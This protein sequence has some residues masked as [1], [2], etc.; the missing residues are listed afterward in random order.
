MA[1]QFY[2]RSYSGSGNIV[3]TFEKPVRKIVI[4]A[5]TQAYINVGETSN[6]A[7]FALPGNESVYIDF[8]TANCGKGVKHLYLQNVMDAAGA[9]SVSVSEY[10]DDSAA[11]D[12]YFNPVEVTTNE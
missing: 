11:D 4:K 2:T 9:V 7:R 10:A 6:L 12:A 1:Q 3:L 5:S 8:Q